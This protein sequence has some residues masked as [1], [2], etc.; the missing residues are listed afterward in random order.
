MR[1]QKEKKNAGRQEDMTLFNYIGIQISRLCLGGRL[2]TAHNYS[3]T[4]KS[5]STF[6]KGNDIGLEQVDE[7]FIDRYNA[8]LVGRGLVRNSISFYM[9]ILRAVYNRAVR[10]KLTPQKFPFQN[11]YTGV[12]RTR[13]RAVNRQVISGIFNLDLP[14]GSKLELSRDLFIFSYLT[15]GMSFVDIA[16][17]KKSDLSHGILTYF[18]KKTGQLLSVRI[19]P[20]AMSIISRWSPDAAR[21]RYLF[22]VIKSDDPKEAYREY[23]NA[24]NSHNRALHKIAGMLGEDCDL[25]SYI[26][27]HTWATTA[28]DCQ[29]PISIISQALGHT[30][31]RTTRIY[32]TDIGNEAI[33]E[34]N[35]T[36][37]SFLSARPDTAIRPR[38]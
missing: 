19:E 31:E 37:I 26:P 23:Q 38:A 1:T 28:R 6:T 29:I 15:R 17:L 27:R 4:L 21:T 14:K 16:F 8:W 24:L 11:V 22:P 33:D 5:I 13:K 36:I 32:L 20:D 10:H 30:S 35:H 7:Q 34:A 25:T 18:R 2:G 12:D 9:R 3:R